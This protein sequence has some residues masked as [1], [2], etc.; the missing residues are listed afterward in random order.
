[1]SVRPLFLLAS[2]C[3]LLTASCI[4]DKKTN[5]Y[6]IE[7]RWELTKGFRNQ[8]ETETLQGVFFQFGAD[9]NM[10]TNLPVGAD[11]PTP[12]E[13]S[14]N[15]I[16]QKSAQEVV[17][18]IQSATDSSLVLA[19]ELRGIQFELQLRKAMPEAPEA[20][21]DSLGQVN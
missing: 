2:C 21:V 6:A 3:L 19:M 15:E 20:P 1:M 17:Y 12:Y 9:G 4:D 10:S 18:T 8:K 16:R 7:G 11:A 14:K 5:P 13:L